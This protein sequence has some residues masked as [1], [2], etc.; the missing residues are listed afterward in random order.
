MKQID[1]ALEPA[2]SPGLMLMNGQP[3]SPT[4]TSS[5]KTSSRLIRDNG[6]QKSLKGPPQ[7]VGLTTLEYNIDQKS[8]INV[9]ELTPIDV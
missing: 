5:N 6:K 3:L 1:Q 4:Q 7:Q 8:I 2:A 9:K